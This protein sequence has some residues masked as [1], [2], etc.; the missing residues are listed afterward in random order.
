MIFAVGGL[1]GGILGVFLGNTAWLAGLIIVGVGIWAIKVKKESVLKA[2]TTMSLA[3]GGQPKG[4]VLKL[5]ELVE[6][7]DRTND[8]GRR[9]LVI[10]T[11]LL[12]V[13]C[14][15]VSRCAG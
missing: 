11:I 6:P 2:V 15:F 7:E 10:G 5:K 9:M 12:V 3:T 14:A 1:L 13:G 8:F 4:F